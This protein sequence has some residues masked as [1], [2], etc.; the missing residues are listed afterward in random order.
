MLAPMTSEKPSMIVQYCSSLGRACGIATYTE[1]LAHAQNMQ[2]VR[3]LNELD[4]RG[5]RP[6]H[7]HVQHE[8]GIMDLGELRRIRR[9]CDEHDIRMCVT[10]H[11]VVE[12]PTVRSYARAFM[13]RKMQPKVWERKVNDHCRTSPQVWTKDL[14]DYDLGSF[15]RFRGTQEFLARSAD[16]LVVHCEAAQEALVAMGAK[17][18]A[19]VPHGARLSTV[20]PTLH[21]VRDGR[22]HVGCFGFLKAHK[23]VLEL[24]DACEKIPNVKLH[25]FA[26]TAH[27]DKQRDYAR[28]VIERAERCDWIEL[29]TSHLPLET[30]ISELSKCDVNVWYCAPPGAIS[31]SGSIRQVLAA[32]RPVIAADHAMVSDIRDLLRV[33]P[34]GDVDALSQAI[35][36]RGMPGTDARP[37]LERTT[38]DLVRAPYDMT[39]A[40]TA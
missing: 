29:D 16:L 22:L 30:I 32:G 40:A 12:L 21:S 19:V 7:L 9:Y 6:T 31:T 28:R 35:A 13:A 24:I 34:F 11:S 38:W 25:I 4:E 18:V 15:F 36:E 39:S 10:M 3:S 8:F 17:R 26:S 37:Y 20:A 14:P 1:M 5:L 2:T 27:I 33:V 23:C